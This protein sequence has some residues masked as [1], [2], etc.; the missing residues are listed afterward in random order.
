MSGRGALRRIGRRGA[1]RVQ[2]TSTDRPRHSES[3]LTGV[4]ALAR[5]YDYI[6]DARFDQVDAEL[7]RACGPAP[8]DACD[9]LDATA[10]VVA[11]PARSREPRPRR[12]VLRGRRSRDRLRRSLDGARAG[13]AP[14]RSSISGG[15]Y[16]ARVQWRVLRD[17]KLAAARDGKRIKVALERAIALDPD[18]DDA[19]FGIGHVSS[20]TPTWRRRPPRSCAS[21]CCCPAATEAEGL[22]Q[23]LRARDARPPAAGRG[24]LPAPDHLPVV[25]APDRR[26]RG[27]PRVAPRPLSRQPALSPQTRPGPGRL[28]ARHHREPRHLARRCWRWRASSDVNESADRRGAGPARRRARSSKRCTRPTTRSSSSIRSSSPSPR[29]RSALSR[30]RTWPSARPRI[31]SATA[32][33]QWPPTAPP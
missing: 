23:M 25:R 10:T 14:R 9:V 18:L 12:R 26:G 11:D 13:R 6:L 33:R 27:D 3:P 22:A 7:Q 16:A 24:R 15:A 20:T 8:P 17:E 1:D 29:G 30:R 5:V 2:R 21:S 4:D 19:Y 32:M 31:V 28:S